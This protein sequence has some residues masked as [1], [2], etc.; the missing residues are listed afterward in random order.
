MEVRGMAARAGVIDRQVLAVQIEYFA[1]EA[2]LLA[3]RACFILGVSN[4]QMAENT[5]G[6]QTDF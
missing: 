5:I 3:G 1:R 2:K 4:Q 6:H